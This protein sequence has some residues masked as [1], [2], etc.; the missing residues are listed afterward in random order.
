MSELKD[1]QEC[2]QPNSIFYLP[3]NPPPELISSHSSLQ[4]SMKDNQF[5]KD[6]L[7]DRILPLLFNRK[8]ATLFRAA[9]NALK[10]RDTS[11]EKLQSEFESTDKKDEEFWENVSDILSEAYDVSIK[12]FSETGFEDFIE[13]L[14]HVRFEKEFKLNDIRKFTKETD[15][16]NFLTEIDTGD[17]IVLSNDSASRVIFVGT[18]SSREYIEPLQ[19]EEEEYFPPLLLELK[20]DKNEIRLS[21]NKSQRN[22][23]VFATRKF[24]NIVLQDEEPESYDKLDIDPK[25]IQKLKTNDCFIRDISI[26]GFSSD[27]S[28]SVSSGSGVIEVQEFVDYDLLVQDKKDVLSIDKC[29]FVYLSEDED[30]LF[31]LNFQTFSGNIDNREFMKISLEMQESSQE[32]RDEIEELLGNYGIDVYEPYHKPPAYY[33]NKLLT[34]NRNYREKYLDSLEQIDS[35]TGLKQITNNDIIMTD[36]DEDYIPLNK[37]ILLEQLQNILSDAAEVDVIIGGRQHRITNVEDADENRI[38]L[39]LKSYSDDSDDS[40]RRF[41]RVIIP[42]RAR[43]DKFEKIYNVIL[44][45]IN[46]HKLMTADSSEEV[47]KYIIRATQRKIRYHQEML[48]EKEARR[49][50]R[51]L[52]DYYPAPKQFRETQDTD[53]KAGYEIEDHLNVVMRYLFRNYLPGGGKNESDGVLQLEGEQYLVDSKQ[54]KEIAQTQL[55]KAKEDLSDTSQGSLGGSERLIFIISKELLYSNTKKGSLNKEARKRVERGNDYSFH[56]VS[57]EFVFEL[58]DVFTENINLIS[59]NPDLQREIFTSIRS[60]IDDSQFTEN[61]VELDEKEDDCIGTIRQLIDDAEYMPEDRFQYF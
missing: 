19:P 38:H 18:K 46:Y 55:S 24:D 1:S 32:I 29:K 22:E 51:I 11:V 30:I 36:S 48:V 27:I 25:F 34:T 26:S 57:V 28:L 42:F 14:I 4:M 2:P 3:V 35:E 45:N 21:G 61:C 39:Q 37:D 60:T 47:V 33:F 43:P 12:D 13:N 23:F 50:A 17:N 7:K 40:H 52:E 49:S 54:S 6:F 41:Y 16:E 59:G 53:Q 20:E 58:Y 56:F 5:E 10:S 31:N 8:S 44:S 9:S 15:P